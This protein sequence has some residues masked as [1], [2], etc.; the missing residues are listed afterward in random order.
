MLL[1]AIR[2]SL[3]S[4]CDSAKISDV[5]DIHWDQKFA[6]N[7][8]FKQI[9]AVAVDPDGNVAIFHRG[10]RV[11]GTSSFDMANRYMEANLG[12]IVDNT[13][14]LLDKSGKVLLRWG[15]NMF[16]LPHGLHIDSQGNYWL[17]DVAL[18]QVCSDFFVFS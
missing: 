17:T 6:K 1:I 9:S 7:L 16:Y 15:S 18:H 4:F 14:V 10:E 2:T 3:L 11:W 5:S 12:P 8:K 13:I